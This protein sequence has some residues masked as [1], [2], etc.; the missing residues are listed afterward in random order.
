[1]FVLSAR[2]KIVGA[3]AVA[4]IVLVAV[5]IITSPEPEKT[6]TDE[7]RIAAIPS[8]AVKMTPSNDSFAPVVHSPLW[9]QP[10]PMPG[11]VNSAGA[12]DSPFMTANGTWFFFFFTP[13]MNVP[14]QEQLVDGVTGIWWTRLVDGTWTS[15]EKIVLNDDVSL[16][17]AECVV[18][19]TMWFASVRAGNLGEIDVYS[20]EYVN[21]KWT[22]VENLGEQLNSVYDIGEFHLTA[23]MST[24]YFHTGMIGAGETMDLWVSHMSGTSWSTPSPLTELNTATWAEGY[25]Y[26]TPDGRELWFTSNR[27]GL[28]GTGPSILRSVKQT[29]GSWGAPEEIISNFAGEPTMDAAGN[30]YFVHH[31]FN[32]LE[33]VIYEADIYVAYRQ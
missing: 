4:L 33:N 14:V 26:L 24:L 29:D 27:S 3:V 23:D 6:I 15:P 1:M 8:T 10:V 20:A 19:T 32:Q 7:D 17:G 22:D 31:Y 5:I 16:E 28:G 2:W 25:P 18:G 21:G 13:D 30:I 9:R 12:E 11:P